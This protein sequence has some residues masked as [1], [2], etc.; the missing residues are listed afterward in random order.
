MAIE[1]DP[2]KDRLNLSRHG[3][4][5]AA[6]D[7]LDWEGLVVRSDLRCDY[8][9]VREIGLGPIGGRLHCVVF[10]RRGGVYRV[11]S[12]RKANRRESRNY[13]KAQAQDHHADAG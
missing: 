6:A 11:I 2:A 10:T 7:E 1:F 8:R 4:S 5:L 13:A 3:I 9:E 12:L